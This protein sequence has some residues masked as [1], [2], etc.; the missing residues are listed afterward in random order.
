[1][2]PSIREESFT[3][4]HQILEYEHEQVFSNP[5]YSL[6]STK[7]NLLKN[8]DRYRDV[9]YVNV[10][11]GVKERVFANYLKDVRFSNFELFNIF[12]HNF[13][14]NFILWSST[15]ESWSLVFY[16]HQ[17]TSLIKLLPCCRRVADS[18]VLLGL[19]GGRSDQITQR[20][21]ICHQLRAKEQVVFWVSVIE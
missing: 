9:V 13:K 4:I 10:R 17:E 5:I 21:P 8:G 15:I 2:S 20:C 14:H 18:T 16:S 7:T 11:F 12:K 1:M 6:H 19:G 3:L